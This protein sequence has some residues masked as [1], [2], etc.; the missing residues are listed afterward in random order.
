[1]SRFAIGLDLS[2]RSPG[3][4]IHDLSKNF[5]HLGAFAQNKKEQNFVYKTSHAQITLFP[6]IPKEST[7]IVDDLV[8]YIH[9]EINIVRFLCAKIPKEHRTSLFT[10]LNV[11]AYAFVDQTA[12]SEKLHEVCGVIKTALYKEGFDSFNPIVNTSWKSTVIGKGR[13]SKLDTCKFMLSNGPC[14]DLLTIFG[15]D[16]ETLNV[17]AKNEKMVPC[18]AQDLAD[19]CAVAMM[20]YTKKQTAKK[21]NQNI[22]VDEEK[23]TKE[24][25]IHSAVFKNSK[26]LPMHRIN[27]KKRKQNNKE[28]FDFEKFIS[29]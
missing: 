6:Q 3:F 19:A 24:A 5:W 8:R 12:H 9:L 27:L 22:I 23:E 4:C 26:C 1:M 14:L 16:E 29:S 15:Y 18:P 7:T 25:C 10:C 21:N 28:P 20:A 2:V 11:E 17:D 13:A